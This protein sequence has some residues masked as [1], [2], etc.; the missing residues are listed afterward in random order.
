MSNPIVKLFQ[1]IAEVVNT[2]VVKERAVNI[3]QI[4][5]SLQ[6]SLELE[7]GPDGYSTAY[8]LDVYVESTGPFAIITKG[9]GKLYKTPVTVGEDSSIT[10]GEMTEVFM[11]FSPVTARQVTVKRMKNG[12]V[13]W[14]AIPACTAVL[15]RSGEIDSRALFDS[16]VE[17]IERTGNYPELDFFHLGESLAL[18]KADWVARDGFLYCASGLF[19][20]TPIARA[21]AKSLEE[22]K[23]YWGLSI[24]YIPTKEPE[25]LR[26]AEGVEVPVYNAGVNRYIS[27]LPEGTAAS[28]LTNISTKEEVNRM[29]K[30]IKDALKELIGEDVDLLNEIV[31]KVD[32]VNRSAEGMINRKANSAPA[33]AEV[34]KRELTEDDVKAVVESAAFKEMVTTIFNELYKVE[35]A[36][37]TEK[38]GEDKEVPVTTPAPAATERSQETDILAAV[39]ALTEK[40]DSLSVSREAEVSE[41]LADLPARISRTNIIRPRATRMPE[42]VR[43]SN[44]VSLSEIAS[45]TLEKMGES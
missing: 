18:G 40:V 24:A 21:A 11:D 12:D 45:R 29:D 22:K 3:G 41:I 43:T 6:K 36:R 42:T 27:I 44:A 30:K 1:S 14:F 4:Y 28:I 5:Q 13:R 38:D 16:F 9:D 32:G 7:K 25:M 10:V 2:Y 17:N 31:E 8:V 15:N 23:D 34:V 33:A 35:E 19:Y 20:D 26:S 39:K 37:T